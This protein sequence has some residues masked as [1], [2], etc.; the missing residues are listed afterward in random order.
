MLIML[1][2]YIYVVAVT[3]T[4]KWPTVGGFLGTE[5]FFFRAFYYFRLRF[6]DRYFFNCLTIGY[7]SFDVKEKN[8]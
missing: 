5:D 8:K 4:L 3:L 2:L 1:A 6:F 7:A